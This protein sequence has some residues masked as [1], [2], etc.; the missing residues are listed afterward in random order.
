[1]FEMH[2]TEFAIGMMPIP[3]K[4]MTTVEAVE[5]LRKNFPEVD[6]WM[7]WWVD[8]TPYQ[9][10]I[11]RF[12]ARAED[13]GQVGAWK[14]ERVPSPYPRLIYWHG[15][16]SHKT[17]ADGWVGV[18]KVSG[19]DGKEFLLFSFLSTRGEV[20]NIYLAS[21]SDKF[22]LERFSHELLDHFTVENGVH[23]HVIGGNDFNIMLRQEDKMLFP[24]GFYEDILSNV[25]SFFENKETFKKLN[26]RTQRGLLFVGPPGN[27]KTMM[28]ASL[29]RESHRRYKTSVFSLQITNYTDAAALDLLFRTALS[30]APA[31]IIMEDLE[32]ITKES[33]IS[34]ASLLGCLDGLE[35]K[36]STLILATS[37]NPKDI[38]P[39]LA[40][41]PSRF[42][43]VWHFKPPDIALR[44]KYLQW[45]FENIS[46]DLIAD[47]ASQTESWSFAYLNELRVTVAILA[48]QSGRGETSSEDLR[49]AHELLAKQFKS[50]RKNHDTSES[51]N[52]VGFA[53]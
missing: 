6:S 18:I 28:V 1:M 38:D 19:P 11:M 7:S 37:N 20:A 36:E 30:S 39:A 49:M 23:V 34:R 2:D 10:A 29:I 27:G 4:G 14:W 47:I 9:N 45:A 53:A 41:R 25:S 12:A 26:I 21:T 44:R 13:S 32:S 33:N 35:Q 52:S 31:I 17:E 46:D 40:H 8:Q 22:L 43:R 50:G 16:D 15:R 42:D 24:D 48:I 5:F 3:L 51:E